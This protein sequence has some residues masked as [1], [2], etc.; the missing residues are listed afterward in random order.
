MTP[1]KRGTRAGGALLAISILAGAAIGIAVGQSTLGLLI[2]TGV[3]A[4]LSLLV[5][6][7]DRR[8]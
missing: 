1:E 7:A 6:M 5:W 3:G 4:L 2:G 8:R